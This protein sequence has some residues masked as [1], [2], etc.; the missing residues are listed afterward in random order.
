MVGSPDNAM[1]GAD[2]S[3][4]LGR[5]IKLYGQLLLDELIIK[6]FTKTKWLVG[7]KYGIQAGF[8]YF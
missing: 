6:N 8:Q 5:S 7:N 3:I 4:K 1:I 2:M